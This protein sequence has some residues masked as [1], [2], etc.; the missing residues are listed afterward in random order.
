M[1]LWWIS[2]DISIWRF[3]HGGIPFFIQLLDWDLPWNKPTIWATK[4]ARGPPGQIHGG[5]SAIHRAYLQ[6]IPGFPR[7]K[8]TLARI[9]CRSHV[10]IG[11]P[12]WS[13]WGVKSPWIFHGIF[14]GIF[15]SS[16]DHKKQQKRSDGCSW[17]YKNL[18][19][20][21]TMDNKLHGFWSINP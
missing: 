15:H 5:G 13:C 1:D 17:S 21:Y 19:N 20:G 18:Q 11:P 2:C 9:G 12:A 6:E 3:I 10:H 8:E 4:G 7:S 14:H 16:H